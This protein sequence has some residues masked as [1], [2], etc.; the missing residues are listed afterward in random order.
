MK[1]IITANEAVNKGIWIKLC[2]MRDVCE[3][4]NVNGSH[5]FTLT[6]EEATKLKIINK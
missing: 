3:W 5:E 6:E 4:I 2:R 1:I